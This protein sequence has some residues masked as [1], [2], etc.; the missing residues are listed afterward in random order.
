MGLG[1]EIIH[2]VAGIRDS[3]T[4]HTVWEKEAGFCP[5]VLD[6]TT[7]TFPKVL[8]AGLLELERTSFYRHSFI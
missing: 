3:P 8:V 6:V 1:R 2:S 4:E 7:E 5:E